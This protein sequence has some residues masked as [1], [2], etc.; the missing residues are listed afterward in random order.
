[1]SSSKTISIKTL[2]ILPLAGLLFMAGIAHAEEAA[3]PKD[4]EHPGMMRGEHEGM[5]EKMREKFMAMNPQEREAFKKEMEERH[6]ALKEKM[7][8]MSPEEQAAFREKMEARREELRAKFEAMSPEQRE[9]FKKKMAMRQE[10]RDELKEHH[11]DMHQNGPEGLDKPPG[12]M[13][14]EKH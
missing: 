9:E 4:G 12:G 5:R 14:P 7:K 11:L 8:S 1:M 3:P 10:H 6:I 13:R 2:S